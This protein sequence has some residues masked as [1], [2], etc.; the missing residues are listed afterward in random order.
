MAVRLPEHLQE[1]VRQFGEVH[2]G[3]HRI[4]VELADGRVYAGVEVAWAEEIIRVPGEPAV[5]FEAGEIAAVYDGSDV[6]Q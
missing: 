1:Q 3:V 5:P 6:G 4:T 2:M